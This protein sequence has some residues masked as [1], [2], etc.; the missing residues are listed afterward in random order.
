M[1]NAQMETDKCENDIR[2]THS[3]KCDMHVRDMH[4]NGK[5]Y[6]DIRV[7]EKRINELMEC[8]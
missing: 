5:W 6:Y 8:I 2:E 1:I 4:K 7:T 3:L